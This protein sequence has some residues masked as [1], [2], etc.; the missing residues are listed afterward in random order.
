MRGRIWQC[1]TDQFRLASADDEAVADLIIQEDL[2][3]HQVQA[4]RGS[5]MG[6]VDVAREGPPPPLESHSPPEEV[7]SLIRRNRNESLLDAL[8]PLT[9][10]RLLH[11]TQSSAPPSIAEQEPAPSS[12]TKFLSKRQRLLELEIAGLLACTTSVVSRTDV[13]VCRE[14]N[15]GGSGATISGG[16][17]GRCQGPPRELDD[18][19]R[20]NHST[21][22]TGTS[23]KE[24]RPPAQSRF[25]GAASKQELWPRRKVKS[26]GQT[27]ESSQ[28]SVRRY[29]R[30]RVAFVFTATRKPV[31]EGVQLHA[32]DGDAHAGIPI[33][34]LTEQWQTARWRSVRVAHNVG[35]ESALRHA[36]PQSWLKRQ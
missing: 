3:D 12:D 11:E 15:H 31:A 29:K 17:V 32:A 19:V 9:H 20:K 10:H 21:S 24:P 25:T 36:V 30:P 16:F 27:M 7:H 1:T 23:G 6:A 35:E 5:P 18:V 2:R 4:Q 28:K 14:G 34:V 33:W 22:P 8:T 13:S 26:N